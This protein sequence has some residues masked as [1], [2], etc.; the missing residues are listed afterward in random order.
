M[1]IRLICVAGARPNFMKVAPFCRELATDPDFEV[2]LV[3]TGQHYDDKMSDQF[4]RELG[5]PKPDYDLE[6]GSASHAQQTAEIMKRFELVVL[7]EQPALVVVAG[8]VNSTVA[9]ALV[10]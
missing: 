10:A 4:F 5:I 9:C 8:D 6:V 3:H 1:P 2:R 7:R